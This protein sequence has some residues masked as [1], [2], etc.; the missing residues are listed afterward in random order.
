MLSKLHKI[1]VLFW[2]WWYTPVIPTTWKQKT[3]GSQLE[4]GIG[5]N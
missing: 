3:E 1:E 4:A 5:K 2:A